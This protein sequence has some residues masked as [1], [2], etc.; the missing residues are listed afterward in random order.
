MLGNLKNLLAGIAMAAAVAVAPAI[1]QEQP[2]LPIGIVDM[3]KVRQDSSAL[4]SIAD[5]VNLY[6][7][8]FQK[9][10]QDE[11]ASLRDAN[12]ELSR[13]RSILSPEAFEDARREFETRVADVQRTVQQRKAELEKVREA[14]MRELHRAL[15]TVIAEIAQ[16][17]GLI[18]VLPRD[19]TILSATSLEI[20]NEVTERLNVQLPDVAVSQPGQ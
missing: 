6:R 19:Q 9:D 15:N 5:Q 11:E 14:A 4:R 10:I 13:Q 1:A 20:T 2:T 12:Q 16:E 8:A 17:R 3:A 18:L 7:N